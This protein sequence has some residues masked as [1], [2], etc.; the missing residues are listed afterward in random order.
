MGR[1]ESLP[2]LFAGGWNIFLMA[3]IE[4]EIPSRTV[5]C[6]SCGGEFG[7]GAGGGSCWCASVPVPETAL[8]ELAKEFRDCLCPECLKRYSESSTTGGSEVESVRKLI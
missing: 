3:E 8:G 2:I 5:E 1:S 6:V 4:M 7:C